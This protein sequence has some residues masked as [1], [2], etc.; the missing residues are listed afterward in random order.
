VRVPL[1]HGQVSVPHELLDGLRARPEHGE[2]C[3]EGVPQTVNPAV[4]ERGQVLGALYE[5]SHSLL[6]ERAAVVE[7]EHPAILRTEP[8]LRPVR[9]QRD[10]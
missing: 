4:G 7:A 10:A 1:G 3:P 9:G 6:S 8:G 2:V 5:D